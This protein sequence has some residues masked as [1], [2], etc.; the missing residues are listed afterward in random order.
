MKLVKSFQKASGL[1][2]LLMIF[3][4][5]AFAIGSPDRVKGK[6]IYSDDLSPVSGGTIEI[7]SAETPEKGR[8]VLEK[9][10]INSDGTFLISR[11][12]LNLS[13]EI[14]I[15]AYP[16]DVDG[17]APEFERS[18]FSPA[19]VIIQT[20]EDFELILR[21]QRTTANTN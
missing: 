4:V 2:F 6:A 3:A 20:K 13:D 14:K 17:S 16:N 8:I 10:T 7:V 15:M 11:N 19:D 9:V 18:E 5:D 12:Y 1:I 21:V